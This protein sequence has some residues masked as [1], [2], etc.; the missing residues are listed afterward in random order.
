MT[1]FAPAF[2]A[3]LCSPVVRLGLAALVAGSML[4]GCSADRSVF[5]ST[6][7]RPAR[8]EVVDTLNRETLW[9]MDVPV[10]QKLVVDFDTRKAKEWEAFDAPR[11]PARFLRWKLYPIGA[12]KAFFDG[13]YVG[14]PLDEGTVELEGNPI[15]LNYQIRPREDDI[16]VGPVPER[17]DAEADRGGEA[18]AEADA[19]A[20]PAEPAMESP[21]EPAVQAPAEDVEEP[22][23]A[24]AEAE[25]DEA[26]E[27][28]DL[29]K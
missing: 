12:R 27:P 4:A 8:V 17:E 6:P 15:M 24:P 19:E 1:A 16:P 7:F 25:A 29:S 22:A 23:H 3:R 13:Y 10:R 18:D 20:Q 2:A 14:K 28:Q 26:D 11:E 21:A 9:A 5:E